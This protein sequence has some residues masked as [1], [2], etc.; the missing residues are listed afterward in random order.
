MLPGSAD[1]HTAAG[2][3]HAT[4]RGARHD[5]ACVRVLGRV[6][7]QLILFD[8][9]NLEA[10]GDLIGFDLAT[11]D[12]RHTRLE[13]ALVDLGQQVLDLGVHH[14][15]EELRVERRVT[16]ATLQTVVARI[17]AMDLGRSNLGLVGNVPVEAVVKGA[18]AVD[19]EADQHEDRR[20]RSDGLV[21]VERV[22][23]DGEDENDLHEADAEEQTVD[24]GS[25]EHAA[26]LV[27][28]DK[29]VHQLILV[30]ERAHP[31]GDGG[32]DD[33]ERC[34]RCVDHGNGR[35]EEEVGVVDPVVEHGRLGVLAHIARGA[36]EEDLLEPH[37][38]QLDGLRQIKDGNV[39][40]KRQPGG[41]AAELLDDGER[42]VVVDLDY[43]LRDEREDDADEREEEE[44]RDDEESK[45]LADEQTVELVARLDASV[46]C[47]PAH[48]EREEEGG[49]AHD[50]GGAQTRDGG[51]GEGAAALPGLEPAKPRD[52]GESGHVGE[53]RDDDKRED[54]HKEEDEEHEEAKEARLCATGTRAGEVPP[55]DAR[56]R[57]CEGDAHAAGLLALE[58]L[59]G[60]HGRRARPRA[61][62]SRTSRASSPGWSRAVDGIYAFAA[63][64]NEAADLLVGRLEGSWFGFLRVLGEDVLEVADEVIVLLDERAVGLVALRDVGEHE[65]TCVEAGLVLFGAEVGPAEADHLAVVIPDE[66]ES[67]NG[68]DVA[69]ANV[70]PHVG[71]VY[72]GHVEVVEL[73]GDEIAATVACV[74]C[75]VDGHEH[76]GHEDGEGGE[77]PAH[78]ADEAEECDAVEADERE[79]VVLL[80]LDDGRDPAKEALGGLG[81]SLAIFGIL[82]LGGVDDLVVGTKDLESKHGEEAEADEGDEGDADFFDV[83]T[84]VGVELLDER[85]G[86]D[87]A[88]FGASC[89]VN[90]G[91]GGRHGGLDGWQ[92]TS[93]TPRATRCRVGVLGLV[94]VCR[95]W[96][97]LCRMDTVPAVLIGLG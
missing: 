65:G 94:D 88:L 23:D 69:H 55:D 91:L 45:E 76:D 80:V 73:V 61:R 84:A 92:A 78:H 68:A 21:V 4:K 87:A 12:H 9:S 97:A 54:V 7:L 95:S 89:Q 81:R 42:A 74:V 40:T 36:S 93:A 8:R 52:G 46:L 82:V 43:E 64:A 50:D 2:H 60:G 17:A 13:A 62:Q 11:V 75:D 51:K 90:E 57:R 5:G 15:C 16:E 26:G 71:A 10:A 39:A 27:F 48:G 67:D 33:D 1:A 31:E 32:K 24:D 14:G 96:V 44:L 86:H 49:D 37:E 56:G 85:V 28:G 19:L 59:G 53:E 58:H 30:D 47:D 25:P 22:E 72:V 34:E 3:R 38:E 83:G 29:H 79:E 35:H 77:H 20:Q 63:D 6:V 70:S 41:V 66:G 18:A